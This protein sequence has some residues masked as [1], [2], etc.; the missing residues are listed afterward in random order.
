[1]KL[2][3]IY[4]HMFLAVHMAKAAHP[5]V[6]GLSMKDVILLELKLKD[7]GNLNS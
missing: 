5:I 4:H 7:N 6:V 1:M 3:N 2:W